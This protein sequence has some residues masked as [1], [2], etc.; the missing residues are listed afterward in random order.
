[1]SQEK[2]SYDDLTLWEGIK[3]VYLWRNG[4]ADMLSTALLDRF[5]STENFPE[6]QQKFPKLYLAFTLWR[7]H[8]CEDTFFKINHFKPTPTD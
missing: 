8:K 6:L 2:L 5:N 1:M 4:Q 3:T 7:R